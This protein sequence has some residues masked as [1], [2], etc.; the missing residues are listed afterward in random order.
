MEFYFLNL[1]WWSGWIRIYPSSRNSS[2]QAASAADY[3]RLCILK[4]SI[5]GP[6]INFGLLQMNTENYATG[7][8]LKKHFYI[9]LN[10]FY[11]FLK[12]KFLY[13]LILFSI[14]M[15]FPVVYTMVSGKITTFVISIFINLK[16]F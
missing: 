8:F 15:F 1:I 10:H 6:Q 3:Y 9:Q 5:V 12:F 4:P 11:V 2:V 14:F 7:G 16:F 13:S